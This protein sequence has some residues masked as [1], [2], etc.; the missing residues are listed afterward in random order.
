M[1]LVRKTSRC[2]S[3]AMFSTVPGFESPSFALRSEKDATASDMA[4]ATGL[5]R[6]IDQ[7]ELDFVS[8]AIVE[9]YA[10][11]PRTASLGGG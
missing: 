6:K 8:A 3:F 1:E 10:P 5:S 2:T 9:S 11:V 4:D 7:A